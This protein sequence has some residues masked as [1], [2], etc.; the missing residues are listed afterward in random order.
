[1]HLKEASPLSCQRQCVAG[2]V[3]C[4]TACSCLLPWCSPF[5]HFL[6]HC[7]EKQRDVIANKGKSRNRRRKRKRA[8]KWSSPVWRTQWI[9]CFNRTANKTNC[10][11]QF[12]LECGWY[13]SSFSLLLSICLAQISRQECYSF[14]SQQKQQKLHLKDHLVSSLRWSH[15]AVNNDGECRLSEGIYVL[16]LVKSRMY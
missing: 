11:S 3:F 1:M 2:Q 7:A 6:A 14:T 4:R 16:H 15:R 12:I 5:G 8:K 10:Q 13:C 9:A